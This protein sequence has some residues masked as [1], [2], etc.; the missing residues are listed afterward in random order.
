MSA[1]VLIHV[2]VWCA[3]NELSLNIDRACVMTFTLFPRS[4]PIYKDKKLKSNK[5]K[6]S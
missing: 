4:I 1:S 5:Y 6:S 2:S 3:V